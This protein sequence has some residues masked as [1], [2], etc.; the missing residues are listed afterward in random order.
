VAELPPGGALL[1]VGVKLAACGALLVE[2]ERLAPPPT[3][4]R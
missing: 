4:P 2:R 1:V 3:S